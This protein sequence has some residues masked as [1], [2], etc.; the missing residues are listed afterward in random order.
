MNYAT[1][2]WEDLG[3][4][5]ELRD[6][7]GG[8]IAEIRP[9]EGREDGTENSW[10][11]QVIGHPL[12]EGYVE[13]RDIARGTVNYKLVAIAM[14]GPELEDLCEAF[15]SS[16]PLGMVAYS[17]HDFKADTGF[18][19]QRCIDE[20]MS[21]SIITGYLKMREMGIIDGIDEAGFRAHLA[22]LL[23]QG[24]PEM[25]LQTMLANLPASDGVRLPDGVTPEMMQL[26]GNLMSLLQQGAGVALTPP[27]NADG[28]PKS[29]LDLANDAESG[30]E[31]DA[32]SLGAGLGQMMGLRDS[33]GNPV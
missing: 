6:G 20:A 2:T 31:A 7:D 26:D 15:A 5:E 12:L 4:R 23:E 24:P 17:I 19:D 13:S 9:V 16:D 22:E 3:E 30:D 21:C 1:C 28:S 14:D 25:N 27:L 11:W 29:L 18:D 32:A 8:A 33:N 10:K